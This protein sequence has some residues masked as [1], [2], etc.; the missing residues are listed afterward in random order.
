MR[1]D[2][3]VEPL[4]ALPPNYVWRSYRGGRLLRRFRGGPEGT[5]DHFPEDWLASTVR[6][7]N[8]VHSRGP[9][10]GLSRVHVGG[11]ERT[12]EEILGAQPEVWFGPG[13]RAARVG[14]LWKLL[15]AAERL[16][17]QAHPDG[18]F[19]RR[20]LGS[21]AGKT[22][23]WY[24]LETRGEAYVH[25]GF[26][27]SPGREQWGRLIREQR[28]AEMLACFDPIPV[29]PGDCFV[30]PAGTPHAIGAGIFMFELQEP[31]DWV[32]RCEMRTSDGEPLPPE[33]CL[34]GLDLERC[35]EVF[36]YQSLSVRA[37]RERWQ[38]TPRPLQRETHFCE[39]ELLHPDWHRFFRLH[40]LRGDGAAAWA[41]GELM[42]AIVLRGEGRVRTGPRVTRV[43]AGQTWL[44]AGCV[45]EWHWVQP[46]GEWEILLAKLPLDTAG[47]AGDS[48]ERRRSC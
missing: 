38:Q 7:R 6:A 44:L 45:A 21:P 32:V 25:L 18:A 13:R 35:L 48:S 42:L 33:A 37:V 28:T 47:G 36:D 11:Q 2:P 17:L 3:Q 20:H 5:D 27:R 29:R 31:T 43:R 46:R 16:Q 30:V 24:V 14:V 4:L 39:E 15:D 34:M 23:C 12:L 8:G 19:A 26:Q 41:G 1:P 9:D 22:E 40:R 10:E